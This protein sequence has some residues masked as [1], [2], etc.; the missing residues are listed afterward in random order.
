M[1]VKTKYPS[2]IHMSVLRDDCEIGINL[3]LEFMLIKLCG[4]RSSNNTGYGK[5]Q[6]K[7]LLR[8]VPFMGL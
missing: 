1:S 2:E 6:R 4:L 3:G 8:Y 7:P 5:E